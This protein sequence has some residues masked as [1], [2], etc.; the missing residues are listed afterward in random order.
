MK[1]HP[2]VAVRGVCREREQRIEAPDRYLHGNTILA[3]H[4]IDG[5]R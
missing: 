3:S 1:V 4:P 2:G 5:N